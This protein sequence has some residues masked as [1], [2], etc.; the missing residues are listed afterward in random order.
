MRRLPGPVVA[1]WAKEPY[2]HQLSVGANRGL[3]FQLQ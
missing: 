3:T 1:D 2:T